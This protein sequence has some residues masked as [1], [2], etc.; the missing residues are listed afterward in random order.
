MD[1]LYNYKGFKYFVTDARYNIYDKR[2]FVVEAGDVKVDNIHK[3]IQ[4]II[5]KKVDDRI[6]TRI[7]L[8]RID[9]NDAFDIYDEDRYLGWMKALPKDMFQC[10]K[11]GQPY[12][13]SMQYGIHNM[14]EYYREVSKELK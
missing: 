1:K 12:H 13:Y 9:D 8:V 5:D 6:R 2:G 3:K 4:E 10:F 14:M 7:T 11:C